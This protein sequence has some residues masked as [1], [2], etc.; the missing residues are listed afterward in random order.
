M[1]KKPDTIVVCIGY[2][3]KDVEQTK[4]QYEFN[5]FCNSNKGGI[6]NECVENITSI[7][8]AKTCLSSWDEL[9]NRITI[10]GKDDIDSKDCD[11]AGP[12]IVSQIFNKTGRKFEKVLEITPKGAIEYETYETM[13]YIIPMSVTDF[14]TYLV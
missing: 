10:I 7:L 12:H 2:T 11:K 8:K 13:E 1:K 9:G 4:V 6:M 14:Q 3:R 5:K